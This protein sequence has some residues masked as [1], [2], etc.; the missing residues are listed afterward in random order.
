MGLEYR[1]SSKNLNSQKINDP[2]KKWANE[3]NRNFSKDEVQMVKKHIKKCSLSLAINE[4]Q[5]KNTNIPLHP[6]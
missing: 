6:S 5:I 4:M 3:L 1:G 2:I